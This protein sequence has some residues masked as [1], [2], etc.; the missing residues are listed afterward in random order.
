MSI[1]KAE[2]LKLKRTPAPFLLLAVVLF[3]SII[4]G[5]ALIMDVHHT[6][7]LGVN[8]WLRVAQGGLVIYTVMLLSPFAILLVSSVIYVEQRANA[9]KM[10]FVLPVSRSHQFFSKLLLLLLL[11]V[12]SAILLL[13][14][15][16]MTGYFVNW[17][18]PEYGFTYFQPE[19][20][21]M[22]T[23]L[24]HGIVS[25]LGVLG[26]QYL[27]SLRFAHFLVALG[28][29]ILGYVL[30]FILAATGSKLALLLPYAYPMVAQDLDAFRFEHRTFPIGNLSNVELYS[31]LWFCG[32]IIAAYFYNRFRD[33]R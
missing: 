8:P 10:L 26:L 25:A 12:G 13:I 21:R 19:W 1:L 27:L 18:L 31:L 6:V 17:L 14:A 7:R 11:L 33:I 20:K 32:A 4:A 30:A 9:W 24:A 23:I 15:L 3:A 5:A 16:L 2:F 28:V 29:G 22:F